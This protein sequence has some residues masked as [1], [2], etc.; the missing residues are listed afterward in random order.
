MEET[1]RRWW[2]AW[3]A[4]FQELHAGPGIAFG[5]GAEAGDDLGLIGD[6][7]GLDV[8]ELG[9]GGGQ[10]GVALAKRGASVVGVDISERQLAHARS[11]AAEHGVD[12][13]FVHASVT[14]L[15]ALPTDRFD[16]AVSAWAFEWVRDLE[17]CFAEAHRV[18][19]P[20][21]RF[22]FSD[23]HPVYQLFDPDEHELR[24]SYFDDTPRREVV[25]RYD[26]EL[27]QYRRSVSAI[28]NAL[29]DA[30]FELDRMLEPGSADSS[31]YESDVLSFDPEL[32]A[33][34]PPTLVIAAS[35]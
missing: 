6:V 20:D 11:L 17:A 10:F 16:L 8:I 1:A 32:M 33:M 2:N 29:L 27:V 18:L 30:G 19:R 14:D 23:E 7:G 3:S 35:A 12:V 22:V 28:V 34:V 13:D 26:A 15:G 31:T 25:E 4:D 9:C 5:P 24:R 21:G